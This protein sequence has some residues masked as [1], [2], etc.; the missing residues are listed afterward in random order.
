MHPRAHRLGRAHGARSSARAWQGRAGLG[1]QLI[2]DLGR[3][4]PIP[5]TFA[6]TGPL[7]RVG[8]ATRTD[9]LCGTFRGRELCFLSQRRDECGPR[10][11]C[12][13]E[14]E[15][16]AIEVCSLCVHIKIRRC[17]PEQKSTAISPSGRIGRSWTV[18]YTNPIAT[19]IRLA[20][21]LRNLVMPPS[22][23]CLGRPDSWWGTRNA[24]G[25]GASRLEPYILVILNAPSRSIGT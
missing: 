21:T 9:R 6:Y 20:A 2:H 3:S 19:P 15:W 25:N 18:C 17:R 16:R 1:S 12:R 11:K 23:V 24:A 22:R 10:V 7:L 14:H 13:C 5:A 8:H 4:A